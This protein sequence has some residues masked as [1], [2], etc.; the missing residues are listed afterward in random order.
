MDPISDSARGR[1]AAVSICVSAH[2]H[3][4]A[5]ANWEKGN[6]ATILKRVIGVV[7]VSAPAF[8]AVTAEVVGRIAPPRILV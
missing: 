3:A 4:R 7:F 1:V 2:G 5:P 6:R 8:S